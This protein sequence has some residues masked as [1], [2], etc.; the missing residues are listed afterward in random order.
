M[1]K[2]SQS[3]SFFIS[4]CYY[5]FA[6]NKS[7]SL[8]PFRHKILK[9]FLGGKARGLRLV[10]LTLDDNCIFFISLFRLDLFIYLFIFLFYYELKPSFYFLSLA[11]VFCIVRG[12]MSRKGESRAIPSEVGLPL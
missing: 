4:F 11:L 9:Q 5:D 2:C 6:F 3:F 1:P 12:L 7:P 10:Y 8:M